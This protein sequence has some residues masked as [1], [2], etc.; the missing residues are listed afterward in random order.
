M[1]DPSSPPAA[2]QGLSE[3]EAASRLRSDG[4]NE[5]PRADRRTPLRIVGEVLREPMLALLLAAG[6]VY[7]A[8]GDLHEALILL[9]FASASIVITVVQIIPEELALRQRFGDQYRSYQ[10]HVAR[11]IGRRR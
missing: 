5:L 1:G 6:V 4:Y 7:L 3:V 9:A 11:W 2:P 8:L 10:R